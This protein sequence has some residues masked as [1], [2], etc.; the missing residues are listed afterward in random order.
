MLHPRNH[1]R[2]TGTKCTSVNVDNSVLNTKLIVLLKIRIAGAKI[3]REAPRM[4]NAGPQLFNLC[5]STDTVLKKSQKLKVILH[6]ICQ[7]CSTYS[8]VHIFKFLHNSPIYVPKPA[9]LP[10]KQFSR[11]FFSQSQIL[12]WVWNLLTMPD[13]ASSSWKWKWIG[14]CEKWKPI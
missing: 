13:N 8:H 1:K 11:N 9:V 6:N 3:I 10:L 4:Y 7:A 5:S 2:C 12:I 14:T